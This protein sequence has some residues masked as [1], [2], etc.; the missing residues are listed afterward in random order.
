[1]KDDR[2]SVHASAIPDRVR[3]GT[4]KAILSKSLVRIHRFRPGV[5]NQINSRLERDRVEW[6]NGVVGRGRGAERKGESEN[7]RDS[8]AER[9]R[10][11]N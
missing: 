9:C 7:H 4:E 6:G 11:L 1:M 5:Q 8:R 3:E 2:V 10:E